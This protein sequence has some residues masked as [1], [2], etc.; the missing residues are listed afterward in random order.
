MQPKNYLIAGGSSGIGQAIATHL[1]ASGH[2]VWTLSRRD[3]A[4]LAGLRHL[5][6]DAT[7]DEIPAGLPDTLHGLV[8]APGTINLRSFRAL[9]PEDFLADFQVN[10]LGAVRLLQAAQPALRKAEQASVLLFSTVA[11]AQGMPFHASVAAA[12]GAVE[13]L[14]RSLAAEW[15][16]NIRVNA[17]APGLVD[18]PLAAR[19]L[20]S[21]VKRE[22]S[23]KRHPLGRVGKPEDIAALAGFLLSEKAAWISG[24]VIGVDGGLS[25][26][27][28]G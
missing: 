9:K 15:A 4:P 14:T 5:I 6:W 24:Q 20:D 10:V 13:G 11:V 3:E 2:A 28:L 19:L 26:L 7:A 12:K 1:L 8:Y 21:E 16:P 22:N 17:I 25:T 18:T 27:R 23:A